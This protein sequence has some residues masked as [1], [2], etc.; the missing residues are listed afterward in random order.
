[1]YGA[2]WGSWSMRFDR[3]ASIPTETDLTARSATYCANGSCRCGPTV[4]WSMAW[5]VSSRE[6]FLFGAMYST[7]RT[8]LLQRW[9][10]M[11]VKPAVFVSSDRSRSCWRAL[12]SRWMW[13]CRRVLLIAEPWLTFLNAVA[14]LGERYSP[15]SRICVA[16]TRS[17]GGS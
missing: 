6:K 17:I 11:N 4:S 16:R 10:F 7:F 12:S 15:G 13:V 3:R 1:M 8:V 5:S 9:G 2:S 14:G